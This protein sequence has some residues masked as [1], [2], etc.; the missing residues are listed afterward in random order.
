[1]RAYWGF[2]RRRNWSSTT[3]PVVC[4]HSLKRG[5]SAEGC[6]AGTAPTGRI[7]LLRSGKTP[8]VSVR[9]RISR[10][11][12]VGPGVCVGDAKP[13]ELP[14]YLPVSLLGVDVYWWTYLIGTLN[15]GRDS[16]TSRYVRRRGGAIVGTQLRNLDRAGRVRVLPSRVVGADGRAVHLAGGTALTVSSVLWCTGLPRD[17][18]ARPGGSGRRLGR[19]RARRRRITRTGPA[20]DGAHVADPAEQL[21]HRRRRPRRACRCPAGPGP[22]A[23]RVTTAG[24]QPR[25]PAICAAYG[26]RSSRSMA[27]A[28]RNG[29][30][31]RKAKAHCQLTPSRSTG[32]R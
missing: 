3:R 32:T 27:I 23:P 10:L 26:E 2:S 1:M 30:G 15:A 14:W 25:P 16:R 13:L 24:R 21:D 6:S 9:R 7:G 28:P 17:V 4:S 11:R 22:L 19:A 20:L 12:L 29:P 5:M 31:A 18:V 8:T